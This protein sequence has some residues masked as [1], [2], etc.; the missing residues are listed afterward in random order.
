VLPANSSP[1]A[2]GACQPTWSEEARLEALD[3]YGILDTGRES[4]FDDIADLAADI[5]D[6]PIAVVNFIT[7][8]RQWFKA[9]KGIGQDSL[10]LEVSICRYA[11]LQPGV[12][13]VPDLTQDT[14][15]ANNP[16]VTAAGGLRFYAGALLETQDG[17]PLGTLCVLDTKARPED[18]RKADA[19]LEGL[20]GPDDGAA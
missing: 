15:F 9:E 17:L 10:P 14:R 1:S 4:G 6:A 7:A 5:L 13:V 12:F 16:L 11:I 20:S 3:Q 2:D 8:D 19:C 18:Q